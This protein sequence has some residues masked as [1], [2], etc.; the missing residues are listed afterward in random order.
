MF[1]LA[2]LLACMSLLASTL[3]VAWLRNEWTLS[4]LCLIIMLTILNLLLLTAPVKVS[5]CCSTFLLSFVLLFCFLVHLATKQ[6]VFV[7]FAHAYTVAVQCC[8]FGWFY[9]EL[10]DGKKL[11]LVLPFGGDWNWQIFLFLFSPFFFV[12]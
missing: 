6:R 4:L 2:V 9:F 10:T 11:W 7:W 3:F 8:G 1:P 5:I 12:R